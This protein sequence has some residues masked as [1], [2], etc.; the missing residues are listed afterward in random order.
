MTDAT[1][2]DGDF[3]FRLVEGWPRIPEGID[4]RAVSGMAVDSQ[5]NVHLAVRTQPRN[6]VLV[7]SA[8]GEYLRSW[9]EDLLVN[10]HGLTIVDDIAYL[11]DLALHEVFVCS[12]DGEVLLTLGS[13][14]PSD[15]G[16]DPDLPDNLTSIRRA[17]GPFNRPTQAMPTSTGEILVADG[18]GNA[19]VHR[20]AADGTLIASWGQPGSAPGQF[21]LVHGLWIDSLDRVYI[22]DRENDRIQIFEV[23][24]TLVEIW[25][26]VP[27][28]AALAL[29]SS[30]N[31]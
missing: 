3:R 13:G 8:E 23:D 18:Y 5:N 22:S 6:R 19:R 1:I 12:L 16:Y 30:G 2:G 21:N 17:A 9:G 20:F 10:A 26:D 28:P 15:T 11:T 27:R 7:Y 31:A 29:D 24:G 14:S 4:Q 25:P